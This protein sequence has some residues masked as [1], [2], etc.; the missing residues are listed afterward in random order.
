MELV[1]QGLNLFF[2]V[3]HTMLALFI[4]LGWAWRP[5]RKWNLL[6]V[7]LTGFS[8]TILGIWY[9]FGYCPCTEWHWRVR[10][11]LG[12]YDMPRSYIKFV[13]DQLTGFDAPANTVDAITFGV[14]AVA[15]ILSVALN[16]HDFLLRRKPPTSKER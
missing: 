7:L 11:H 3:F 5:A 4:V 14:F 6:S 10:M 1:Y 15:A 2:Y 12:Y 9:G 8:W 16:A 13:F